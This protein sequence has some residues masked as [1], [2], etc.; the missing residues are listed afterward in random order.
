MNITSSVPLSSLIEPNRDDFASSATEVAGVGALHGL[1]STDKPADDGQV[2]DHDDTA[3]TAQVASV[4]ATSSSPTS[5]LQTLGS[6]TLTVQVT[7]MDRLS[8]AELDRWRMIRAMRPEFSTPFFSPEFSAAVHRSR[9]DVQVAI[10]FDE[11]QADGSQ[12]IGFLPFHRFR[13]SA[14][15]VGRFLN[16]AHNIICPP[17]VQIDWLWLLEQLDV[18]AFDFHAMVGAEAETL[19]PHSHGLIQ[20]FRADVG[21]DSAAYLK[22]LGKAHKTIG[23]QG[24]KTR[25]MEREIGPVSFVF[26]CRDTQLLHQ[27]IQWKR[28]QYQ[29]THI[30]DLFSTQWTRTLMDELFVADGAPDNRE[31]PRGILSVLYAGDRVVAAHYGLIENDLLHYWFPAYT[32]EFSRYS[33]GTAL[34]TAIL[35]DATQNG[36]RCVDMG[37]GE[38]PY[39]LK[40]TDA[41]GSVA[42]GC[43][44]RSRFHRGW[45]AVETAAISTIKKMPLK[46][47]LKR[48]WRRI[49]PQA[50][51]SK[52][53]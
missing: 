11:S 29:R 35:T 26:D 14:V 46:E 48:V 10:L 21:D 49:Q 38:Q 50:G 42:F 43:I 39:K 30:L 2:H 40:Q 52:L 19:A 3:K 9:G 51:I 36:I 8:E 53:R 4:D 22:R 15:P 28:E 31:R 12:P 41:T 47:S 17:D 18:K 44:T 34:F 25:K 37:Y 24:Q 23:R 45:R 6:P 16:D 5:K 1:S 7:A 27:T 32:P 20:S 33:P 13:G